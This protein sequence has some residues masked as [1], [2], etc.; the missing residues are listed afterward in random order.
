MGIFNI[1]HQSAGLI[2]DMAYRP[3]VRSCAGPG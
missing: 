2:N 3:G 1:H